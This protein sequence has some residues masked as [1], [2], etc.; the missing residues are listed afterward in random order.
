MFQKLYKKLTVAAMLML[1]FVC[2]ALP[3]LATEG[4]TATVTPAQ[5][6]TSLGTGM[7]AAQGHALSGINTALPIALVIA[8]VIMAVTI[9]WRIFRRMSRG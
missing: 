5:V 2:S 7:T 9:G 3:A 1:A 4:E 8:G 6:I